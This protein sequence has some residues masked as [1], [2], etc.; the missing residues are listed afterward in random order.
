MPFARL[1]TLAALAC[2]LAVATPSISGAA[3]AG[4]EPNRPSVPAIPSIIENWGFRLAP[5]DAATQSAGA[6]SLAPIPF[7]EGSVIQRPISYFGAGPSRPQDPAGFIDPQMTFILPIGTVVTAI[8][9]GRVCWV[10]KLENDYS[11][12]YSIGIA[13]ACGGNPAA[14]QGFG[15][16]A[17]WEH[18]HVMAPR[19]KVG[20]RVKA[21][22]PIATVSYYTTQNWLYA[23]GLGLYEIGI[24]TGSPDG[25]PM[26]LCPARYLAPPR[27]A[28]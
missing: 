26:H 6:M 28:A 10:K 3:T 20:D 14:G 7:P 2:A 9:S 4:R 25:R 5:Y 27:R 1:L 18:E 17:T 13:P 24:L 11:D 12:D 22:Q 23:A 8:A 16:G 21:G 15:T 19:V